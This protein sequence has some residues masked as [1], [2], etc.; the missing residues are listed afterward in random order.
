MAEFWELVSVFADQLSALK[1]R[2]RGTV[3]EEHT[4]HVRKTKE[5]VAGTTVHDYVNFT[6]LNQQTYKYLDVYNVMYMN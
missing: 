6:V 5:N 4:V 1:E 2:N 3:D